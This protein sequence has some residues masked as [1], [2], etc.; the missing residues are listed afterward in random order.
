MVR[1]RVQ[2]TARTL[3]SLQTMAQEIDSATKPQTSDSA[4]AG[5]ATDPTTGD[6]G[7]ETGLQELLADLGVS[8]EDAQRLS[9]VDVRQ[10]LVRMYVKVLASRQ[11]M[12][13]DQ[14]ID[15][16]VQTPEEW[17]RA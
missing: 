11:K 12:T 1:N 6:G 17:H 3:R 9:S 15:L 14:L 4:T 10:S 2:I 5:A 16:I 8:N 13:T 7:D